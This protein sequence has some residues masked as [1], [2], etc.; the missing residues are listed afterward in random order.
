MVTAGSEGNCWSGMAALEGN[1]LP[2]GVEEIA[3]A[4]G[5]SQAAGRGIED[6]IDGSS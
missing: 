6:I 5:S 4:R 3:T 1:G 2:K